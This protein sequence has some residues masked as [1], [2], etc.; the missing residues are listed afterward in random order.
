MDISSTLP[1]PRAFNIAMKIVEEHEGLEVTEEL[2]D[3]LNEILQQKLAETEIDVDNVYIAID[4]AH[5][6]I[7]P[8]KLNVRFGASRKGQGNRQ[9]VFYEDFMNSGKRP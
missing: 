6:K 8:D 3:K 9:V 7:S 4:K 1:N 2:A 5:D